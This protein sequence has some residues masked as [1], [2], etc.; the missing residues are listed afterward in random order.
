VNVSII[1]TDNNYWCFG[2]RTISSVLTR[3]GHS[4]QLILLPSDSGEYSPAVVDEVRRLVRPAGLIGFSCFS[5]GSRNVR[6]LAAAL[7][8]SGTPL[9]W[10]GLH[11]TLNPAECAET[12][13]IVC[14]GEGEE[15]IVELAEALERG[16]DWGEI[17][18][19]T[20]FRNASLATN[21]I[22]PPLACMDDLPFYDFER[23]NE[24]QLTGT[25]L[26]RL[27][28]RDTQPRQVQ[29]I[30]SRGCAF[31]C[32]Y[33]SNR[34]LKELYA[35]TGKY[36]RRMSPARYVEHLE[37]LTKEQFPN[38]TD[39]FLL[40]EDF[41]QRPVAEMR[42]FASLYRS[43]IGL[44]LDCLASAPRIIED[45]LKPLVEAGLWRLSIGA[46]SG[47]E[48]TKRELYD[49][50]ISNESMLAASRLIAK[51]PKVTPCYFFIVGNPYEDRNDLLETARL[52]LNFERP[53][54]V[55]IYNL[56][57]FP[58]SALYDRAVRDG[59]ISGTVDSG[60][61]LDYRSGYKIE[62]H[63]WKQRD[64]FLNALLFLTEGKVT[65]RRM[66]LVPD[67]L[68]RLMIRPSV[69]SFMD[70]RPGLCRLMIRAK[71]VV[72]GLRARAGAKLR[73]F[74]RNPADIYDAR[75]LLKS[76]VR[77]ILSPARAS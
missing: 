67:F 66:G 30:G 65:R 34:R 2:A 53:Y 68:F 15:T 64:V 39:V 41:F 52:L 45:K 18:N 12:V 38:A 74:V 49:R 71:A 43:R 63:A 4:T 36:L 44:P 3:A 1:C 20:Y 62:Q 77:R 61:E 54:Q 26:I 6:Q 32:T 58:G 8:G 21:P 46:E 42:E 22:R 13:D 55:N 10:G 16:A 5:R 28:G 56:V 35:G 29:F 47:S 48:R 24:Y 23:R 40:D 76:I 75:L 60:C 14:R 70:R 31:H 17:R 25:G 50:P 72:L 19:L 37:K 11:A 7:R 73:T 69:I 33:C 57:F 51:Y 59:I 27:T 9:V